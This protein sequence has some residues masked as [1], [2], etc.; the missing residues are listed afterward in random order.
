MDTKFKKEKVWTP[1]Y[2]PPT[3][4][5]IKHLVVSDLYLFYKSIYIYYKEQYWG[6]WLNFIMNQSDN[7][8]NML[9]FL[10]FLTIAFL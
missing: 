1:V 3:N 5:N 4:D 9:I 10:I 2:S 8:L 7:I 6:R